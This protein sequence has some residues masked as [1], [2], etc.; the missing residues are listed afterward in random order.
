VDPYRRLFGALTALSGLLLLGALGYWLLGHGRWSYGDCLYMTTITV[1]TVGFGELPHMAEV[2]GA[3]LLTGIIAATGLGVV[4]YSQGSLTVLIFE[5]AF[6]EAFRKRKMIKTI[7]ALHGH[8]VVAGGGATGRHVIEELFATGTPFVVIDQS[9]PHM[10]RLSDELCEGKLL[11]VV[12]DA[13]DD[14]ALIAAGVRRASG[15]VAALTD[16]RDN[17]F[18]TLSARSLNPTARIVSKVIDDPT[19]AK[20][21]KAGASSVVSPTQIGGRRIASEL[22]RPTVNEFFDQMFRDNRT[23]R[24]E[25]VTVPHGSSCVGK[26]LK[27]TLIRKETRLL[28]IAVKKGTESFVYNPEPDLVLQVGH[29]LIVMGEVTS[30]LK[31]RKLIADSI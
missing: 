19:E 30:V 20:M 5:G 13:T 7:E 9:E 6:G 18:V 24:L 8:V 11:Y 23:L 4:A 15:V 10:K 27:D 25:E 31:L 1:T 29:T 14:H 12:G 3:R 17:V 16:D 26:A 22:L 21:L 28:V 2:R